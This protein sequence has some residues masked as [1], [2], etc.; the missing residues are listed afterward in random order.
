MSHVLWEDEKQFKEGYVLVCENGDIVMSQTSIDL[1]KWD[2]ASRIHSCRSEHE[3]ILIV[4]CV[5]AVPEPIV[6]LRTPT[7][8]KLTAD[9]T[10]LWDWTSSEKKW[11]SHGHD[12]KAFH[13]WR[14]VSG[15]TEKRVQ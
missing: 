5:F 9:S 1:L 4:M 2:L 14:D 13:H 10:G 7:S 8:G 6:L 15:A 3:T 11:Q 12:T